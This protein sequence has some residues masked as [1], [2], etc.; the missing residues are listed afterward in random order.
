M[1]SY[2]QKILSVLFP[3]HCPVCGQLTDSASPQLCPICAEQLQKEHALPCPICRKEAWECRCVPDALS[4]HN[5]RIICSRFYEA[6]NTRAVSSRL[7]YA[8]KHRAD[9]TAAHILAQSMA[10]DILREFLPTGE[11]IR[12]WTITYAPRSSRGYEKNGFD[13]AQRLAKLCAR[14]TGARYERLFRRHGGV[15]QKQLNALQRSDNAAASIRLRRPR[16]KCTG[17]YIV[18]DDITT[19]GAT[20]AECAALLRAGNAEAVLAASAFRTLPR[21]KRQPAGQELW[22]ARAEKYNQ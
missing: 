22:Y 2:L 15:E 17:K 5:I 13:Q 7:V 1:N 19:T 9:D 8:L 6:G 14:Y 11:D 16:Q 20:L 3:R 21:A 18:L 10:R 4:A 12:T